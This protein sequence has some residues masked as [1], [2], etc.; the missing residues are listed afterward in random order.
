M[1]GIFDIDGPIMTFMSKLADIMI[2]NFCMLICCIPIFTIGAAITAAHKVFLQMALS[3]D[4]VK[5]VRTFF[6]GF[7]ENF[8]QATMVWAVL[9]VAILG[10]VCNIILVM[11]YCK[12]TLA[13]ILYILLGLLTLIV[14]MI[15]NFLFPLMARY[16]NTVKEHLHNAIYLSLLRI[17]TSLFMIIVLVVP[18]LLWNSS[19]EILLS[20]WLYWVLVGLALPIYLDSR[21][22]KRV[23]QGLEKAKAKKE[24]QLPESENEDEDAYE[25]DVAGENENAEEETE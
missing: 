21:L 17:Y 20:S 14:T 24:G 4:Q 12:G 2:V 11:A 3:E 13:V 10:L 25:E 6:R 15:C 23:F 7:K 16:Q 19:T 18:I 5:I 9:M 1:K 8:K 22:L